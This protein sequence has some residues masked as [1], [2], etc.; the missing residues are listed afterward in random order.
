MFQGLGIQGSGISVFRE[1]RVQGFKCSGIQ[2]PGISGLRDLK[3]RVP[4]TVWG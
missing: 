1:F 2:G 4:I 3:F